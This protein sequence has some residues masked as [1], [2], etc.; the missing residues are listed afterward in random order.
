VG[1]TAKILETPRPEIHG[2]VEGEELVAARDLELPVLG[3]VFRSKLIT[4]STPN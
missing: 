2:K 4:D 3:C 1:V